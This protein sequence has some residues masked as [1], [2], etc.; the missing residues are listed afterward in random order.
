MA[1]RGSC[2]A[3]RR[4]GPPLCMAI[5]Q[6][7]TAMCVAKASAPISLNDRPF[8]RWYAAMYFLQA[9]ASFSSLARRAS[10]STLVSGIKPSPVGIEPL[11]PMPAL[12][13]LRYDHRGVGQLTPL[14]V[15]ADY[16]RCPVW[17]QRAS[18]GRHPCL[19]A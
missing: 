5:S 14:S 19:P 17:S 8:L 13:P 9:F 11:R 10:S 2:A 18:V 15:L 6:Y 3:G 16:R 12:P 7:L 1:C 4:L